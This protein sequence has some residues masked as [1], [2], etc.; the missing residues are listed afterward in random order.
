MCHEAERAR[1]SVSGE[2]CVSECI[3]IEIQGHA[4]IMEVSAR[5][6]ARVRLPAILRPAPSLVISTKGANM[7]LR[8]PLFTALQ[9]WMI[10]V[11]S[12]SAQCKL[13]W[14]C[15]SHHEYS[16]AGESRSLRQVS[17]GFFA[18][19]LFEWVVRA[20]YNRVNGSVAVTKTLAWLVPALL[21]L[22]AEFIL[23]LMKD[24]RGSLLA[25]S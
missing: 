19:I 6:L 7:T 21:L 4:V 3:E 20:I 22:L 2:H 9:V 16:H 5:R 10:R 11:K 18:F 13:G 15:S 8:Y 17:K 24:S 1:R 25:L 12:R 14:L 23:G